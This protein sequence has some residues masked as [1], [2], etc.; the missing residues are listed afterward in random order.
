[1]AN[2]DA[3]ILSTEPGIRTILADELNRAMAANTS[4]RAAY[5][6]LYG[7]EWSMLGFDETKSYAQ[8]TALGTVR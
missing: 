2:V 8:T 6:A 3:M 7:A 4:A 1:M 5:T